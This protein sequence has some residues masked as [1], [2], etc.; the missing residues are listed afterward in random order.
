MNAQAEIV[1]E[2]CCNAAQ[3]IMHN[4]MEIGKEDQVEL[5]ERLEPIGRALSE[6]WEDADEQDHTS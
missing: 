3:E 2:C 6:L 4:Y 1:Y 5:W